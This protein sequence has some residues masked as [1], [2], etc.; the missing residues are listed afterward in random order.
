MSERFTRERVRHEL[1]RRSLRVLRT[2]EAAPGI[3]RITL[4]GADLS[5]FAAPGPADHV[6]LFFPSPD[7]E[8]SVARDYTPR[9]FRPDAAGGPEL[10]I[11]FVLHWHEG[12][13]GGPAAAWAAAAREGDSLEIGGPRGSALPPH[14]VD[15]AIL[16]ADESALPAAARWLEAL[17]TE[18]PVVGLFAVEDEATAS[19]LAT[20]AGPGRE[21]HWF[22]GRDRE[23]RLGEALRGMEI[24]EGTLLFLAGE[25]AGL[26]PLRRYLRRELG[27]PK[28]QVDVSGYWKRGAA[29]HDH[30]APVDPDDAD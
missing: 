7:G 28:Q 22:T 6:K 21:L 4:G 25:A 15:A 27:L 24:G 16:V 18:V 1:R 26:I 10:D 5:D 2:S 3:A 17:G 14:D 19:Y 13:P 8:E 11:D 12:A 20:H 30:H 29:G 9:A 23:A